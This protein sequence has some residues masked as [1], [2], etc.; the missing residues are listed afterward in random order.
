MCPLG[1]VH[2]HWQQIIV[3][4]RDNPNQDPQIAVFWRQ[5]WFQPIIFSI[6]YFPHPTGAAGFKTKPCSALLTC[7]RKDTI[8][9]FTRALLFAWW[10]FVTDNLLVL[11]H[12][13]H[14]CFT[15][16][17][18]YQCVHVMFSCRSQCHRAISKHCGHHGEPLG[19]VP[20]WD[21]AGSLCTNSFV[22]KKHVS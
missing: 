4:I 13:C 17:N 11:E 8:Q 14:L 5:P 19:F 18:H 7:G 10:S 6:Q 21:T 12:T 15:S 22:L 9:R 2:K 20:L 16:V 3:N 1:L